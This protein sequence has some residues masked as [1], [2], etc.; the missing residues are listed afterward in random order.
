MQ[1]VKRNITVSILAALLIL[2][3]SVGTVFAYLK[4]DVGSVQNSFSAAKDPSPTIKEE[5]FDKKI[6]KNVSV[7][8]GT[9]GYSVYV[10][11]AIVVT[12][13][14]ENGN[15]LADVPVLGED[16]SM[17]VDETA[18]FEHNGFYY[19]KAAVISTDVEGSSKTAVLINEAACIKDAPQ[20]G[21]YLSVEIISQTI[22][23]LGTTD[24]DNTPA[25]TDA[26]GVDVDEYNNLKKPQQ[27]DK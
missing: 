16:Y 10:R 13:K 9:P 3:C 8:V 23:A 26:W 25:V 15:V 20:D 18:W 2:L 7:D 12:W 17:S 6:K 14:D 21:Y 19:H 5:A 4:A 24:D 1:I 27:S 11:A 22:Q